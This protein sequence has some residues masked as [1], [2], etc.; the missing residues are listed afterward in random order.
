MEKSRN[1]TDANCEVHFG[2]S[3]IRKTPTIYHN[4]EPQW[5]TTFTFESIND[6]ELQENVLKIVVVDEDVISRDDPIGQVIIDLS[7]L[8]NINERHNIKGSFPIFDISNGL[9]GTLEVEVK[10]TFV[11]D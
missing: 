8:L 4:L 2:K 10:L 1:T 9:R 6:E 11:R 5:D 3:E 7:S